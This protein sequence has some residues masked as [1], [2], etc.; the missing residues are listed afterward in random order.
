[1]N[2]GDTTSANVTLTEESVGEDVACIELPNQDDNILERTQV[3]DLSATAVPF[4]ESETVVFS[5]GADRAEY[6]LTDDEGT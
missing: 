2:V 4:I 5:R 3:Y 6:T 1:M